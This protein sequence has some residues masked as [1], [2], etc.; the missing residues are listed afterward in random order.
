MQSMF[1]VF[2][3][4]QFIRVVNNVSHDQALRIAAFHKR[5]GDLIRIRRDSKSLLWHVY[6]HTPQ[7]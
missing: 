1:R 4:K 7:N 3:N 5:E 6:C 2:K